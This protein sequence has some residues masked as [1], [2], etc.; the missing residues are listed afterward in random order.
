MLSTAY[1]QSTC[2]LSFLFVYLLK[3]EAADIKP[4]SVVADDESTHLND[5]LNATNYS[6][7]P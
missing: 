6:V 4:E 5:K 1:R 7:Y 3:T 2:V